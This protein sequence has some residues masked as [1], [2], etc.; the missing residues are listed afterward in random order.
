MLVEWEADEERE[1]PREPWRDA[2]ESDERDKVLL[3]ITPK[4]KGFVFQ[5]LRNYYAEN[6]EFVI[7]GSQVND[8]LTEEHFEM[9]WV[10]LV[11]IER[12]PIPMSSDASAD[13]MMD[14]LHKS[15]SSQRQTQEVDVGEVDEPEDWIGSL[16]EDFDSL[17][18][19]TGSE[20]GVDELWNIHTVIYSDYVE[21]RGDI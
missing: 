14:T 1:K 21:G 12:V 10:E 11:C 15:V 17:S 20:V 9:G 6:D 7:L 2:L 4:L 18:S 16:I 19:P 8:Y 3:R 5:F 13:Q